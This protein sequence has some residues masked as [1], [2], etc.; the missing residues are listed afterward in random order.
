M[1]P[2][3]TC[4]RRFVHDPNCENLRAQRRS[5][6][7]EQTRKKERAAE[8]AAIAPS[9]A[10]QSLWLVGSPVQQL[11]HWRNL[12]QNQSSQDE[13]KPRPGDEAPPG[14]AN[15]PKFNGPWFTVP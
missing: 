8:R 11:G 2:C 9:G 14:D 1:R 7:R 6:K 15:L 3:R 5:E 13:A 4:G 10:Q 12:Q